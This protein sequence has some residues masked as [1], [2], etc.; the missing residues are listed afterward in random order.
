MPGIRHPSGRMV[1]G[2]GAFSRHLGLYPHSGGV[3]PLLGTQAAGFRT[4]KGGLL[5]T[6]ARPLPE[7]LVI[8]IL[9]LRL[10]E[11]SAS[12]AKSASGH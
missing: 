12:L 3:I 8:R 5:F 11:I 6:P 4:S 9:D 1:A 7:A 10:A 2:Y